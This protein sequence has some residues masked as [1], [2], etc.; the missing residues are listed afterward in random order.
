MQKKANT[1]SRFRG[2]DTVV[3]MGQ[4]KRKV[5]GGF[6]LPTKTTKPAAADRAGFEI[7]FRR[8]Q[9]SR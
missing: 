3:G 2:N 8:D 1:G 6:V 7:Q 9:P 5:K 4:G